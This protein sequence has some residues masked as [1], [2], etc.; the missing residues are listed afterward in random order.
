MEKNIKKLSLL[1]IVL[2]ILLLC[3][4]PFFA[5]T[6]LIHLFILVMIWA[7]VAASW[8][9][10]IGFFGIFS[11]AQVAFLAL[12]AYFSGIIT[13]RYQI[14]PWI[15][16]LLDLLFI[17]IIS[18]IIGWTIIRLKGAY[19]AIIT[20]CFVK[21]S[22]L[23]IS[24]W[25]K[26]TRGEKS[27]WGIPTIFSGEKMQLKYYYCI[28]VLSLMIFIFMYYMSKSKYGYAAKAIKEAPSAAESL[29]INI[30]T[31][32]IFGFILSAVMTGIVGWFYAHY[33]NVLSPSLLDI[34]SM[35]TVLVMGMLGGI[36]SIFGPAIGS[37]VITFSL[38]Y[39]RD[40]GAYRFLLYGILMI[41]I[42]LYQPKGLYG[43]I[44]TI[45][46]KIEGDKK[47]E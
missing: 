4:I 29:G 17:A 15:V 45:K 18:F 26:V 8:D 24:N 13:I 19:V 2:F 35:V 36:G 44:M 10:L 27:L 21:I 5:G 14:S 9:M 40:I 47:N 25:T 1:F 39:L 20:V 37:F 42:M 33:I 31:F 28:L 38:E 3:F 16:L 12:A 7:V 6:Y 41:V 11:F 43:M 46:N 30:Q 32:K 22:Q 34:D 23:I